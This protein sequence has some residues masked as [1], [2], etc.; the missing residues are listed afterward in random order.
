MFFIPLSNMSSFRWTKYHERGLSNILRLKYSFEN[1]IC[2]LKPFSSFQVR[3]TFQCWPYPVRVSLVCS[4][5]KQRP[6]QFPGQRVNLLSPSRWFGTIFW[7]KWRNYSWK[8]QILKHFAS[9]PLFLDE[10]CHKTQTAGAASVAFF[11]NRLQKPL[12]KC[13]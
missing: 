3:F 6:L 13:L 8:V 1:M 11:I 12:R 9:D 7:A 10:A 2:F 4:F 5:Y